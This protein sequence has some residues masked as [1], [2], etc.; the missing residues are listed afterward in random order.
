MCLCQ[1]PMIKQGS[2]L[3]TGCADKTQQINPF[4]CGSIQRYLISCSLYSGKPFTAWR[5]TLF[6]YCKQIPPKQ[7]LSTFSSCVCVWIH[8]LHSETQNGRRNT[9]TGMRWIIHVATQGASKWLMSFR[10]TFKSSHTLRCVFS[11]SSCC[12]LLIPSS[13]L[14]SF[15]LHYRKQTHK[16]YRHASH[17]TATQCQHTHTHTHTHTHSSQTE[18]IAMMDTKAR[19]WKLRPDITSNQGLITAQ[20]ISL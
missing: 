10:K 12:Q 7:T 15:H 20:C 6:W 4:I 2:T 19:G 1:L 17:N 8:W 9:A 11:L 3:P 14:P 18:D 5:S 16:Y 13:W